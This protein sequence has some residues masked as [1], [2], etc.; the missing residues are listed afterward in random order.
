VTKNEFG[1]YE[2]NIDGRT[3]SFEKWGADESF[4]VLLDISSIV[5][6]SL[7][8]AVGSA[9]SGDGLSAEVNPGM[10]ATVFESLSKNLKK[11]VVKPIVKK[12]CA[13]KVL[14]DGKK[15]NFNEHY[16]EDLF[17]MFRVAKAGLEVQY[18]NFFAAAQGA[19]GLK[20]VVINRVS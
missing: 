17:H 5:G 19:V 10:L 18:G 2:E 13:E 1:L 7:G 8:Q 12:L 3:Y 15:I 20:P 4:D 11:D 6:G 14:C 16:K 9:I